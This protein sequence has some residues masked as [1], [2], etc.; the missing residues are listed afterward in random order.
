MYYIREAS[1]AVDMKAIAS[2]VAIFLPSSDITDTKNE[3]I[4]QKTPIQI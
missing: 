4:Y 1:V 2:D 3:S